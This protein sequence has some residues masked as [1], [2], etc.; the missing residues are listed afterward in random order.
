MIIKSKDDLQQM[1]TQKPD[2]V[3]LAF[4]AL[5]AATNEIWTNRFNDLLKE[6][7]CTSGQQFLL[8]T[9]PVYII[10]VVGLVAFTAIPH[11]ILVLAFLAMLFVTG[12]TGK[13]V[14]L[15]QRKKKLEQLINRFLSENKIA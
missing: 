4:S 11:K 5:D 7:G 3:T 13:L 6:C 9:T 12:L 1:V 14:G 15:W 2:Q 10:M 8:Y